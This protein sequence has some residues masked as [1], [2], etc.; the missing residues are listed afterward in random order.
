VCASRVFINSFG[1]IQ[2]ND[3]LESCQDLSM[4]SKIYLGQNSLIRVI[5]CTQFA[6][7]RNSLYSGIFCYNNGLKSSARRRP[8]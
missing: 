6:Y 5:R 3:K 8:R 1:S 4:E 7:P 2:I